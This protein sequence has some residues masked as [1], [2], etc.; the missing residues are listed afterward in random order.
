MEE[1]PYKNVLR[2]VMRLVPAQT[3]ASSL[4]QPLHLS[5]VSSNCEPNRLIWEE[6]K[7]IKNEVRNILSVFLSC[8][9][10]FGPSTIL[11]AFQESKP[12][13]EGAPTQAAPMSEKELKG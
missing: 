4:D 6:I 8:A 1:S 5:K 2:P 7:M 11:S 9:L 13:D 12:A 3:G 10:V